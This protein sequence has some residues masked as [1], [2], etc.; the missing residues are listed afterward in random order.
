[1]DRFGDPV[2]ESTLVTGA[3]LMMELE[4]AQLLGLRMV[5]SLSGPKPG[6]QNPD[7]TFSLPLWKALIDAGAALDLSGFQDDGT[8][9][10]HMLI[11]EPKCTICWGGQ[12]IPDDVLDE[13]AAYSKGYWPDWPTA[14]R[15]APDQ[16]E[17]G[18]WN[19]Q[20]LDIGWAQ[21][22][23]SR[24]PIDVYADLQ[25]ESAEIQ[26]LRLVVGLN[27]LSGGD[28]SSAYPAPPDLS[29]WSMSAA[30]IE[31]YGSALLGR[32]SACAFFVWQHRNHADYPF[33]ELPDITQAFERLADEAAQR[34]VAPCDA[35][36]P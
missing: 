25:Q 17:D 8:A 7:G 18:G 9:A 20:S 22:V 11:D 32:T 13:M 19:W 2:F 31:S 24:G 16:L 4:R 3:P 6:S 23:A 36:T 27:V 28:G 29:G 35:A 14:V 10:F 15:A 26:G 34:P 33:F 5:V 30:E 12:E 1:M 21:Y